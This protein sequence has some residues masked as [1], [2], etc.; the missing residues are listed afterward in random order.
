M[1]DILK[2][3]I[4]N[5]ETGYYYPED[6]D[7]ARGDYPY[8]IFIQI[9]RKRLKEINKDYW[10]YYVYKKHYYKLLTLEEKE[11][12]INITASQFKSWAI[13]LLN[14]ATE[15]NSTKYQKLELQEIINKINEINSNIPNIIQSLQREEDN[16][17]RRVGKLVQKDKGKGLLGSATS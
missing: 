8:K 1:E 16:Q 3:I 6:L 10:F 4:E 5:K 14:K 2:E 12:N 9:I 15:I 7:R 13:V 17:P 11:D